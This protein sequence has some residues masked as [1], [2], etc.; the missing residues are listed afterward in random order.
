MHTFRKIVLLIT[1]LLLNCIPYLWA[2]QNKINSIEI[3]GITNYVDTRVP[4][5][6]SRIK[7]TYTWK[8][9]LKTEHK[10]NQFLDF[11]HAVENFEKNTI[12]D[13]NG[14]RLRI[15]FIY[16]N[17]EISSKVFSE[18]DYDNLVDCIT[19]YFLNL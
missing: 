8:M 10:E 17:K 1:I 15:D 16:K 19:L 13:K 4:V 9:E 14:I 7:D 11:Y 6:E 12:V 2:Q 3:Y 5:T 18:K